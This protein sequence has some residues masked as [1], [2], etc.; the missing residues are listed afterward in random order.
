MLNEFEF[1]YQGEKVYTGM[2]MPDQ[3]FPSLSFQPF[4][5]PKVLSLEEIADR[6][7]NPNLLKVEQEWANEVEWFNQG[8]K[9]SCNAYMISWMMAVRKWRQ[10]GLKQR[11]S[12]EWLYSKINGG[13]DQGSMLDDGMVEAAD[14]GFCPFKPEFYEK[15]SQRQF[16][17]EQKRWAAQNSKDFRFQECYKAP[18]DSFEK[19]MLSLYSCLAG[20]GVIGMAVHVGNQYMRSGKTAGYD[21]GP[22]NHAVA[23]VGLVLKTPNPRS[24]EDI[25][26]VSPQSWGARFANKG[27]TNIDAKL[28]NQPGRYHAMYCVST[29]SAPVGEFDFLN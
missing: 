4:P 7:K 1:E 12:P 16:N 18:K 14:E 3:S 26:I 28:L 17:M 25:Q 11:F 5:A 2:K 10:T 6:V 19:M 23:G 29:V 24:I 9:S 22:G 21:R 15:Y 8:S 27:F 20:G 13:K